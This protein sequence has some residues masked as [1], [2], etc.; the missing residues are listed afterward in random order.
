MRLRPGLSQTLVSSFSKEEVIEK[1]KRKTQ[2]IRSDT[3]TSDPLFNGYFKNNSFWVS[4]VY[5][6]SQNAIP[7]AKGE[8]EDTSRGSIIFLKIRL[9][10]AAQLYLGLFSFFSLL[11]ALIF[12]VLTDMHMG[13]IASL[14]AGLTNYIILTINFHR[15][16]SEMLNSIREILADKEPDN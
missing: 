16:A 2:I 8:V 4:L 10:P 7:L 11:I 12:L 3:I 15:K 9:F 1:I 14:F 13:G 6:Y 5:N